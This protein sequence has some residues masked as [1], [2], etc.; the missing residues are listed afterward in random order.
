M[1]TNLKFIR[2]VNIYLDKY[3]KFTY[4]DVEISYKMIPVV[5]Y[6][7]DSDDY[8]ESL[9]DEHEKFIEMC[10]GKFINSIHVIN[11]ITSSIYSI[12][13][14]ENI[15]KKFGDKLI[16]FSIVEVR[17][18]D[19]CE[20]TFTSDVVEALSKLSGVSKVQIRDCSSTLHM[21]SYLELRK[22]VSNLAHI[23]SK[24]IGVCN[25]YITDYENCC[26]SA[27]YIRELQSF[28]NNDKMP[29][30]TKNHQNNDMCHCVRYIKVETDIGIRPNEEK[31]AKIVKLGKKIPKF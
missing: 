8:I 7:F 24:K 9:D 4:N 6:E 15:N 18:D 23:D 2:P 20:M 27:A 30:V 25:S 29:L 3:G 12:K 17:D 21:E 19:V 22:F 13:C 26:L 5:I 16:V 11:V 28:S 10:I 31:V 14:I 1:I